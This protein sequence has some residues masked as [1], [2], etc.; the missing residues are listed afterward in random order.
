MTD[1][2]RERFDQ[3]YAPNRVPQY[4]I[5]AYEK[6]AFLMN[7]VDA[8]AFTVR[9]L[10]VIAGCA[11]A[12]SGNTA[13][14]IAGPKEIDVMAP[15]PI[16]GPTTTTTAQ[17][18]VQAPAQ[19]TGGRMDAPP[20]STE[21]SRSTTEVQL[22]ALTEDEL[23]AH[24]E[25]V[26]GLSVPEGL[27]RLNI[28]NFILGRPMQTVRRNPPAAKPKP[29][30]GKRKPKGMAEFRM[31]KMKITELRKHALE[32]YGF[33]APKNYSVPTLA[34]VLQATPLLEQDE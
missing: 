16:N 32:L 2:I 17:P 19:G 27:D 26:L 23:R 22:G 7:K 34:A 29:E 15:I 25:G 10:C 13:A 28:V 33:K 31:K 30:T 1:G 24:A 11:E 8:P 3:M 14:P 12:R 4:V 20:I 5:D 18:P 6:A 21:K 9:D